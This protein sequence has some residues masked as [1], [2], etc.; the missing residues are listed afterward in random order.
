MDALL[1][2]VYHEKQEPGTMTC[3]Q[4]ALNALLQGH[5][6][7][8]E[9]L[10]NI[11]RGLDHAEHHIEV[12]A[13]GRASS[14]VDETGF[15]SVQVLEQALQV[16][17]LSLDNWRSAEM[18]PF[19]S[20]P[21]DQFAFVLNH[22]Q[23]WFIIR[24][25]GP[26]PGYWYNLNSFHD[27]QWLSHT[28]LGMFLNQ[29]ET[30]GYTIFAVRPLNPEAPNA[31]PI[32]PADEIATDLLTLYGPTSHAPT[33]QQMESLATGVPI[34]SEDDVELAAAIAASL[35]DTGKSDP[36]VS[37]RSPAEDRYA[38][39]SGYQAASMD[40]LFDMAAARHAPAPP[41][42]R[43]GPSRAPDMDTDVSDAQLAESVSRSTAALQKF[44][45]SSAEDLPEAAPSSNRKRNAGS[46]HGAPKRRRTAGDDDEEETMRRALAASRTEGDAY[47]EGDDVDDAEDAD[48]TY[49]LGPFAR[50]AHGQVQP[51]RAEDR[52]LDDEDMELQAALRASLE[53]PSAAGVLT[54]PE[55]VMPVRTSSSGSGTPAVPTPAI[56]TPATPPPPGAITVQETETEEVPEDED[57]E[58]E[59]V[60]PQSE[61]AEPSLEEIRARRLARFGA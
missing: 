47:L 59:R 20:R 34:P 36:V 37:D 13:S 19:N 48:K 33:A 29:A 3:G 1:P 22:A 58:D 10:A 31:I 42:P 38:E 6:F 4:Y 27:A 46:E 8:E 49:D 24:R 25:F 21:E 15:F 53:D 43:A 57:E 39:V 55:E 2:H 11:G 18:R 35:Q 50:G 23:H 40:S 41:E 14:N 16:W 17:N 32:C 30:E 44:R 12:D 61:S 45:M 60:Q 54:I 9:D 26:P 5:Y 52:V 51:V 28:Y 7:G 56:A